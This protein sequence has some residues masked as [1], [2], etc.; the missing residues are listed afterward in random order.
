MIAWGIII[1]VVGTLLLQEVGKA[2]GNWVKSK[3]D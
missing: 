1:G 2:F 3:L